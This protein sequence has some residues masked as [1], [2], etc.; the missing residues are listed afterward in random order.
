MF[1][2]E[3]EGILQLI[4]IA[5]GLSGDCA[6]PFSR[7]HRT[8]TSYTRSK[9]NGQVVGRQLLLIQMWMAGGIDFNDDGGGVVTAGVGDCF[10][11]N[12][13]CLADSFHRW[14]FIHQEML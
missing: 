5:G 12:S 4:Q 14:R 13:L 3:E 2:S 11:H 6:L 9:P 1:P 10:A 8:L 7:Q